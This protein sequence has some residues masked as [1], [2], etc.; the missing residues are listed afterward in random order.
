MP[1]AIWVGERLRDTDFMTHYPD[2]NQ[3]II[4]Y[5]SIG[6]RSEKFGESLQRQGYTNV[7]NLYGSLFAWK[8]KGYPIVNTEGNPTDSVHV[9]SKEW[10]QYLKKGVKVY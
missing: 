2:K 3:K 1:N 7:R 6:V 10:S 4:V 5:C 9:Y 8:N